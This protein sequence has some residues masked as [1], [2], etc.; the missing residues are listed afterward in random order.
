MQSLIALVQRRGSQVP[1]SLLRVL[2][3]SIAWA[4]FAEE[5]LPC[6]DVTNAHHV[7][8]SIAFFGTSTWMLVGFGGRAGGLAFAAVLDYMVFWL[9]RT[10]VPD[11]G[12][13]HTT[14]LAYAVTYTALLDNTAALS[15]DRWLETA[16]DAGAALRRG[17]TWPYRVLALQISSI[18][19]WSAIDKTERPFLDGSRLIQI[20]VEVYW[21]SDWVVPAPLWTVAAIAA[22]IVVVIEYLLPF[23]LWFRRT[24]AA[25][26]AVGVTLHAM[27]YVLLPVGTFSVTMIACYLAYF[28][29]DEVERAVLALFQPP[30]RSDAGPQPA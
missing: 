16:R 23:T 12:H 4:R 18:Y 8:L 6:H 17:A 30:P 27:F 1:A 2:L 22:W 9:G 7:L 19:F 26:V 21:H 3:P 24:R 13:H 10:T 14:T 25:S 28:D 29:P 15:V 11:W 5:L 20:F